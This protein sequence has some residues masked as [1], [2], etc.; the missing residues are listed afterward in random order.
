MKKTEVKTKINLG[1]AI[2]RFILC[3]WI[4]LIHC[5]H[6]KKQHAQYLNKEFHVPTFI[7]ISFFFY[8]PMFNGKIVNKII[9]RFQRLLIPYLIWPFIVLIINNIVLS[10]CKYGYTLKHVTIKDIF[11]Q[12]LIGCKIHAIFWFQFNLLF[13]SLF[14]TLIAFLFNKTVLKV[15]IFSGIISFF[16]HISKLSYNFFI[17][18]EKFFGM[19]MGSLIELLPMAVMGSIISSKY[20]AL[21]VKYCSI[22][23]YFVL[24]FVIFILF[25]Y[26]I[27]IYQP[28]FRYPNVSMN[29][30]ASTNLFLFFSSLPFEKIKHEKCIVFNHKS[31]NII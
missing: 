31:S 14:L 4:V 28:G 29:I 11:I 3:F 16:L 17:K 6:V 22:Y 12:I 20:N 2:L 18:Y 27:F 21:K 7:L 25:Q 15:I 13:L 26:N 10:G 19:N 8:F 24:A 5:S 1:I 30:F 23:S 9:S